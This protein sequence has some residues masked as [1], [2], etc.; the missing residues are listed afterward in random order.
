MRHNSFSYF[1]GFRCFLLCLLRIRAQVLFENLYL[2]THIR[3]RRS[4]FVACLLSIHCALIYVVRIWLIPNISQCEQN[5]YKVFFPLHALFFRCCSILFFPQLYS[6]G[7]ICAQAILCL[8]IKLFTCLILIYFMCECRKKRT[9]ATATATAAEEAASF[10]HT[11]HS[12][13]EAMP[14]SFFWQCQ[15][16]HSQIKI[17]QK[18]RTVWRCLLCKISSMKL[19]NNEFKSWKKMDEKKH[20]KNTKF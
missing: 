10:K 7:K 14:C 9:T 18:K 17:E 1:F 3:K 20:T 15:P 13:L 16:M 12:E 5:V 2:Q 6:S 4:V 8:L 11:K 19:T